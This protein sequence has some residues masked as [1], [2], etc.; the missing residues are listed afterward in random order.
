[1]SIPTSASP[2]DSR[3]SSGYA[4]FQT[5]HPEFVE[6]IKTLR[7][8][9]DRKLARL[10]TMPRRLQHGEVRRLLGCSTLHLLYAFEALKAKRQL[11]GVTP[12]DVATLAAACAPFGRVIEF[13]ETR[14]V[15]KGHRTRLVQNFGPQRRMHQLL[16]ADLL[17]TLH[18]P[19]QDQFLLNGGMPMALRAVE[20][21]FRAGYTHAVEVDLIDFYGR[22]RLPG[23]A[24]LLRPLPCAVTDHVIWD[25]SARRSSDDLVPSHSMIHPTASGLVGLSLGAAT[26]PV[27]GE[28]ILRHLLD[29]AQI[30]QVV[31]Y[32]DNIL[33][34][35][36]GADDVTMRAEHLR[37]VAL[38]LEV[39]PLAPRIGQPVGFRDQWNYVEFAGHWGH[40]IRHRLNWEPNERKQQEHRLADES[41]MLSAE[42]IAKA[43]RKVSHCRRAYPMWRGADR[44][45]AQRLAE[46]AAVRYYQDARPE[47]LTNAQHKLAIA[48]LT[49]NGLD[50]LELIPDGTTK[51]HRGRRMD[52]WRE[53]RSLL[54]AMQT[55]NAPQAA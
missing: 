54:E 26:S 14:F 18:S 25:V 27:V 1:M 12:D 8:Q 48:Y 13:I 23:L 29:T 20:A 47:N 32:A 2:Q 15:C 34:L 41:S 37:E 4:H 7:A 24:E 33:V 42:E 19:R 39:G 16:V 28:I 6:R 40:A 55:G 21:A 17:R 53:T 10:A 35:G 22:V 46:L 3:S 45:E 44:W 5:R 51:R 43:E 11:Q 30:G 31:I 49:S 50:L 52:L 9:R 36:Q 38:R